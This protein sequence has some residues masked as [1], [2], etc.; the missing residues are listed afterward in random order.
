MAQLNSC[1]LQRYILC[2]ISPR[3]R[4]LNDPVGVLVH[5]IFLER[6][7]VLTLLQC[8]EGERY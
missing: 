5:G 3:G 6:G 7:K 4:V 1:S 8:N 2:N